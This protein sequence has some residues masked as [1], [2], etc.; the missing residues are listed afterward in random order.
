MEKRKQRVVTDVQVHRQRQISAQ[1][2]RVVFRVDHND[3]PAADALPGR[4]E[5]SPRPVAVH[6]R[7]RCPLGQTMPEHVLQC[8]LEGHR[9]EFHAVRESGLG[10]RAVEVVDILALHDPGSPT[11]GFRHDVALAQHRRLLDLEYRAVEAPWL[12]AGTAP[13][14]HI[15][16]FRKPSVMPRDFHPVHRSFQPRARSRSPCRFCTNMSTPSVS[17]PTA[18]GSRTPP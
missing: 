13:P 9:T 5:G 18:T 11:E 1:V 4:M 7:E 16:Q 2:E 6:D 15:G 17:Q 12:G 10:K 3:I 8:L 14:K